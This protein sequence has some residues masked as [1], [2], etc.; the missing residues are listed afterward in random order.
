MGD[1]ANCC[2]FLRFYLFE[3]LHG[4]LVIQVKQVTIVYLPDLLKVSQRCLYENAEL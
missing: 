1:V 2:R 3:L 4:V